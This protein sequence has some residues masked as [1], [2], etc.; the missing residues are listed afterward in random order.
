[1]KRSTRTLFGSAI[2]LLT[3]ILTACGGTAGGTSGGKL[4]I[5]FLPKAINN[6]YFDSAAGGAKKAAD[7][8][9]GTF[10]QVG[11]SQANAADQVPFIQTLTQQQVSAIVVSAND[12][13]ALAPALK[14][15]QSKGIKVVSYDSD[16][17][18]DARS[19]FVN[20]A[21]TEDIGRTEVQ[22]LGAQLNYTGEI[23][24]LSAASTA[25]NQNAWID[26]MK[27]ELSLPKYSNMKLVKVA[28][29][30]DDDQTSYNQTQALVQAYPNLKGIISPT[31]VGIAAAARYLEAN[32]L[33]GKIALTGLGTPNGLRKYVKDGTIK[34]FE[35]W[36]VG[37]LGYL[38]YYAAAALVQG[39]ITGKEGDTFTAGT[40]GSYT[41]GKDGE[42]LLGKPTVFDSANIDQFNF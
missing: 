39:K 7:E 22:V 2:L 21:S 38:A 16:V 6:P 10:K 29:G 40:L 25:T 8:L 37:H 24:I 9:K 4:D 42:V 27:Q 11:P 14:Q 15:A 30:N 20:Q 35:L 32:G 19:I 17:A 3:A 23:A 26:Y 34:Q 5:A 12:P 31:T 18:H 13:N 33:S 36:D 1:M 41:V 28:Y